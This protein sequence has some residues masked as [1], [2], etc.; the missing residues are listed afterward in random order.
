MWIYQ[1]LYD[2][3]K[4]KEATS[5]EH[6]AACVYMG[7]KQLQQETF[8]LSGPQSHPALAVTVQRAI[9][10]AAVRQQPTHHSASPL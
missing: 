2:L 9:A 10:P 1:K 7:H 4:C 3:D 8:T 5:P 6:E